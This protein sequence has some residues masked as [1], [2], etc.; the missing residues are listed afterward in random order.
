MKRNEYAEEEDNFLPNQQQPNHDIF[1]L[2]ARYF[3]SLVLRAST[4][5]L[6]AGTSYDFRSTRQPMIFKSSG[7]G[8][9]TLIH[10][11]DQPPQWEG[12]TASCGFSI[13]FVDDALKWLHPFVCQHIFLQVC[14]DKKGCRK[15]HGAMQKTPFQVT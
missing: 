4:V 2:K 13:F 14:L 10:H 5:T 12:K 3:L 9:L 15:N 1:P 6:I 7:G 11:L 8:T